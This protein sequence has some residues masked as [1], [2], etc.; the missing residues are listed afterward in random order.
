MNVA[1]DFISQVQQKSQHLNDEKKL[2]ILQIID[3]FLPQYDEWD[4]EELSEN[5]L[6]HIRI[7]EQ[8]LATGAHGSWANIKRD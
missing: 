2:L 4:D 5:D 7:G 1:T 8:E 3:N 6:H